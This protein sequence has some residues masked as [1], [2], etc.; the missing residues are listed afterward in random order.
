MQNI[1]RTLIAAVTM[2]LVFMAFATGMVKWTSSALYRAD[3][4]VSQEK[5][6][7]LSRYHGTDAL[8]ITEFEVSIWRN[9]EWIP[10]L[11]NEKI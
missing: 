7:S 5:L 3:Y 8:K 1:A 9:E 6:H 4:W 10:V 2:W 11:K